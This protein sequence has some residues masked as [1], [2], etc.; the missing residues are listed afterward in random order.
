MST[1][2]SRIRKKR[3]EAGL[4]VDDLAKKLNK[5]RATVYRYENGDIENFPISVIGPLADALDTTPAYLMGWVDLDDGDLLATIPLAYMD[6]ADGDMEKALQFMKAV[7]EDARSERNE[8]NQYLVIPSELKGTAIAFHRGEFEGLTQ[9]E[10][11]MLAA[12]AKTL[13]E[14]RAEKGGA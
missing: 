10:V 14:K 6:A 9:D 11:D 8:L 7:D 2:G 13:K 12:L 1:T 4:S 3:L 5:N